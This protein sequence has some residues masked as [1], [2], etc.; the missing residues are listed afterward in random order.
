MLLS[1]F[2]IMLNGPVF[3]VVVLSVVSSWDRSMTCSP[4]LNTFGDLRATILDLCSEMLLSLVSDIFRIVESSKRVHF[5]LK[6]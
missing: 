2:F 1:I 6:R 4:G 3:L 5:F